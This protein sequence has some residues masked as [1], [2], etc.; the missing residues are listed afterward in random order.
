MDTPLPFGAISTVLL[1]IFLLPVV[2]VFQCYYNKA[3]RR[4]AHNLD[5]THKVEAVPLHEMPEAGAEACLRHEMLKW[6]P[7]L[8]LQKESITNENYKTAAKRLG[9]KPHPAKEPEMN[10]AKLDPNRHVT[11]A[12]SCLVYIVY[13]NDVC[14]GEIEKEENTADINS[15]SPPPSPPPASP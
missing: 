11:F 7:R 6:Y 2:A 14:R 3:Q 9:V 13:E 5:V 12:D 1:S 10:F 15:Q 8:E 4:E